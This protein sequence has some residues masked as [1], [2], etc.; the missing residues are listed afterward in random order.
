MIHQVLRTETTVRCADEPKHGALLC[1]SRHFG[2]WRIPTVAR[3]EFHR[4]RRCCRLIIDR[5]DVHFP[6]GVVILAQVAGGAS[7]G[8]RGAR[9]CRGC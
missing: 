5:F 7:G 1:D 8:A 3:A 9:D 4:T 2:P 6:D